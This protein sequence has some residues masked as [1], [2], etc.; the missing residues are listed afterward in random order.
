[1][2]SDDQ[3]NRDRDDLA[4][5]R[6][7]RNTGRMRRFLP[8]DASPQRDK[9]DNEERDVLLAHSID[10]SL[11]QLR[12]RL[13]EIER[14]ARE[15]L[16]EAEERLRRA[17]DAYAALQQQAHRLEDGR[18][19]YRSETD[20][21]VYDEEGRV[22]AIDPVDVAGPSYEE[23]RGAVAG[24]RQALAQREAAIDYLDRVKEA[25]ERYGS[26][27]LSG[28]ERDAFEADLLLLEEDMP[29]S[30]GDRLQ[31][32]QEA[33]A[34]DPGA[35]EGTKPLSPVLPS[36]PALTKAF[37]ASAADRPPAQPS[38]GGVPGTSPAP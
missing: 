22:V 1:M 19:V 31:G 35:G 2:A 3:Q 5:E 20:G 34:P 36:A 18:R 7:G 10:V 33:Q 32:P 21:L 29:S 27:P 12:S 30:V 11:A 16:L 37:A 4:N 8:V 9:R 26:G 25:Q 23:Y 38:P 24:Q 13:D 17:Q 28:D 6:A 15:A 14:A